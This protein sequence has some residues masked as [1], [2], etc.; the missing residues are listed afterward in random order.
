MQWLTLFTNVTSYGKTLL[1]EGQLYQALTR[2]RVFCA[3]SDQ[4]L[5]FL[6]HNYEHLQK[7][8][9]SHNF[10]CLWVRTTS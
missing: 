4:S 7:I 3:A 6:T 1:I 8:I 2:R 10:P 9:F 5:V